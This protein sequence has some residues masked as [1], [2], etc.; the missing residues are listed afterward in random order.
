MPLAGSAGLVSGAVAIAPANDS[1]SSPTERRSLR[2]ATR[3][4]GC[5]PEAGPQPGDEVSDKLGLVSE[6]GQFH[7]SES[8]LGSRL[9]P[10]SCPGG[11][12]RAIAVS[13]PICGASRPLVSLGA[14]ELFLTVSPVCGRRNER[15]GSLVHLSADAEWS[16]AAAKLASQAGVRLPSS[17]AGGTVPGLGAKQAEGEMGRE[18]SASVGSVRPGETEAIMEDRGWRMATAVTD[19]RY[20]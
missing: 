12:S 13:W 3:G 6:A 20:S 17:G 14:H 9:L 16:E 4:S 7:A 11:A 15:S 2:T 18:R 5:G 8:W 19:R 1:E 10:R